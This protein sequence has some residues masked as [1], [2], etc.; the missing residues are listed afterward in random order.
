MYNYPVYPV[1]RAAFRHT[2]T[3]WPRFLVKVTDYHLF[4]RASPIWLV[5]TH[6]RTARA[7]FPTRIR[8]H[9]HGAACSDFFMFS[10]RLSR[11][12]SPFLLLFNSTTTTSQDL[13]P[14]PPKLTATRH[15]ILLS[16]LFTS[17]S[18]LNPSSGASKRLFEISNFS[19][20]GEI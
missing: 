15:E 18:R 5:V 11:F 3:L 17:T 16:F 7:A 2:S 14:S 9:V 10:F 1:T 19:S 8:T 12:A 20:L 6:T 4:L 13:P